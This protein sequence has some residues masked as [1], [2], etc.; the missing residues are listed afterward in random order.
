MNEI[1]IV[2]VVLNLIL[3]T[4]IIL[5]QQSRSDYGLTEQIRDLL[6]KELKENR[7]ELTSSIKDN[8]EEMAKGID[9]LTRKLEEK[10]IN[11]LEIGRAHV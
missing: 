3:S 9:K 1:L 11:S 10:L 8:R 5:K 6:S 4:Y 2:L 7:T